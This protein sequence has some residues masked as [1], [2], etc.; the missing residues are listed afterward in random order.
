MLHGWTRLSST[1]VAPAPSAWDGAAL[2]QSAFI[3]CFTPGFVCDVRGEGA[4]G[5]L[6]ASPSASHVLQGSDWWSEGRV[7]VAPLQVA[8]DTPL[9][10]YCIFQLL[11]APSLQSNPMGCQ[12]QAPEVMS[13]ARAGKAAVMGWDREAGESNS[14]SPQRMLG[15]QPHWMC[16]MRLLFDLNEFPDLLGCG[17]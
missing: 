5:W 3:G 10:F 15:S 2:P 6:V 17:M 7:V 9:C 1:N 8:A 13:S 14:C 12:E 11:L 4:A 16:C